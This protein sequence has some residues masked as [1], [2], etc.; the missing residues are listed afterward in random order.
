MAVNETDQWTPDELGGEV[1]ITSELLLRSGAT[2]VS[3]EDAQ[4]IIAERLRVAFGRPS[5][6]FAPALL[7]SGR[8]DMAV[9]LAQ[10]IT[11]ALPQDALYDEVVKVVDLRPYLSAI[12]RFPDK[13]HRYRQ[14]FAFDSNINLAR[15]AENYNKAIRDTATANLQSDLANSAIPIERRQQLIDV[16]LAYDEGVADL[17]PEVRNREQA[18]ALDEQGGVS[19]NWETKQGG[20]LEDETN[21][22]IF[23]MGDQE[24]YRATLGEEQSVFDEVPLDKNLYVTME[25]GQDRGGQ[26]FNMMSVTQARQYLDTLDDKA[27]A[28]WQRKLYQSG[29]FDKVGSGYVEGDRYDR[30]TD[31]AWQLLLLESFKGNQPI[32]NTLARSYTSRKEQLNKRWSE[33][34]RTDFLPMA[35]A[36]SMDIL[37]R[38][39]RPEEYE[40]VR[41]YIGSLQQQ[42]ITQGGPDMLTDDQAMTGF[43]ERDLQRGLTYA[44]G[45]LRSQITPEAEEAFADVRTYWEKQR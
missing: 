7:G 23:N 41:R 10:L 9:P 32:M 37:G 17:D 25:S 5:S 38:R 45:G 8:G 39:L 31:R 29:Y 11:S 2:S 22:P 18:P 12:S 30:A 26:R 34:M 16:E 14:P 28:D 24:R 15:A 3:R 20:I 43:D 36:I 33:T 44:T 4:R 21:Q 1:Q 42:R 35:D 13:Q 19:P 27:Y 40:S 6:T